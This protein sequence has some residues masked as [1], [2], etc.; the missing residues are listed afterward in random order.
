MGG[1]VSLLVASA[2]GVLAGHA[3]ARQGA[4]AERK[5]LSRN[6]GDEA[7]GIRAMTGLGMFLGCATTGS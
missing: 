6:W 5:S 3:R 1:M 7:S 2:M 4:G